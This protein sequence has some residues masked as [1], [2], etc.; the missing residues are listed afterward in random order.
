MGKR[1][2]ATC[3]IDVIRFVFP[4]TQ[5]LSFAYF[6]DFAIVLAHCVA[7]RTGVWG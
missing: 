1:F 6:H 3:C 4:T 7:L 2:G 5:G